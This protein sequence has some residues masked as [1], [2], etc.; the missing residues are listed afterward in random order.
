MATL[1]LAHDIG[2]TGDKATLFRDDGTLV[3]ASFA[4]YPTTYLRPGWAEQSPAA[5]WDAFCRSTKSLLESTGSTPGQVAVVAFSGTMMA[6]LPVDREGNPLRDSI[7]WADQR[8]TAEVAELARRVSPERV[9]AITGHRLSASYSAPKMMWIRANEPELFARAAAFI[10]TKDFL[11]LKL[12]GRVCTDFSDATGMNL[13]DIGSLEWSPE[14]LEAAGIPARLLPEIL[15]SPTVVGKVTRAAAAG[16]GLAQGTPVVLGGGDGACATCGSGVVR[17]GDVYLSLGTSTWLGSASRKPLLDPKMR[18]VTYGHF[19]RDL[20]YLCGSMQAGGGSLKWFTEAV[21]CDL[22]DDNG[23]AGEAEQVPQVRQVPQGC[24]GLLFLPYLMGER[25]PWWNST[26]RACFIGLTMRHTR[27]HMLR[28]VMEG[29]AHNMG[30]IADAFAEQGLRFGEV[31]IIGGGARS[32]FW[33]QILAD[34]LERPVS[35]LNF[36][37]EAASIGAAIAGGV[38]VGIFGSIE[39]AARIVRVVETTAP[40][41]A[42]FAGYRRARAIFVRAYEQLVPVFDMI[43]DQ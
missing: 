26:A 38:G 39:D 9:Y 34:V 16:C 18:T 22:P 12:T 2:T 20:Y 6:A 36:M 43:A 5:Y 40:R 13:L 3:A 1:I 10:H 11:V 28:A 15:E 37:E 17:E 27:A 33:R 25:S 30:V 14:M 19:R 7:I 32:R 41:E 23:G 31:R 21:G 4:A 29:V 24:E 8:S 42:S 35:T